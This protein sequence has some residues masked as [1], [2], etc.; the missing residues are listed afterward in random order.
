MAA[1]KVEITSTETVKPSSPTPN[2]LRTHKLTILDQTAPPAYVPLCLFFPR[3]RD[4]S[5][6]QDSFA[7]SLKDS[8]SNTLNVYY[9]LA[10]RYR[11]DFSIDC[12]DAG[13][14]LVR[15]RVGCHLSDALGQETVDEDRLLPLLPC[16]PQGRRVDSD[17]ELVLLAVQVSFFECGGLSVGVCCWHG[18]SD[19]CTLACF[20]RTWSGFA[21]KIMDESS[22]VVRDCTDVFPPRDLSAA[23]ESVEGFR[24]AVATPG[25]RIKRFVFGRDKIAALRRDIEAANS[26]QRP[27]RVQA[28][29]AV[30]WAA[31]IKI[32]RVKNEG[33][34]QCHIA[35][36]TTNLRSRME[37]ALP[38][39]AM[40]NLV[41]IPV[42]AERPVDNDDDYNALAAKLRE[43]VKMVNDENMRKAMGS[44]FSNVLRRFAEEYA[45][46]NLLAISSWCRFPFYE[47]DFGIGKPIWM[48]F[49]TMCYNLVVLLDA[50]DGVGIEAWVT[51]SEEDMS[52]FEK[53]VGVLKYATCSKSIVGVHH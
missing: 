36:M 17:G 23:S 31:A 33:R 21:M 11:D 46:G 13:V 1:L 22:G 48:C 2:H 8:L 6:D 9:P 53:D 32:A 7:E 24:A 34:G 35:A 26:Q 10:G 41:Q 49:F 18:V 25:T 19:A 28:V 43:S 16:R 52:K 3:R 37:P 14:D 50:E 51:L 29:S 5:Y 42:F 27:S 12:N 40:G 15:A 44:G 20:L 47:V 30:I 38:E 4:S 39:Q 45:E